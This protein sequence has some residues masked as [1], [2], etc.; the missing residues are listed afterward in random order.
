M[1]LE[2]GMELLD[3]SSYSSRDDALAFSPAALEVYVDVVT[4]IRCSRD[5]QSSLQ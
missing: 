5:L 4:L 2:G 1:F 3:F